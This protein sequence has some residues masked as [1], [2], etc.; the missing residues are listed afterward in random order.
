LTIADAAEQLGVTAKTVRE[1]I[2]KGIIPAPP[3]FDYGVRRMFHFPSDYMKRAKAEIEKHKKNRA[4][5]HK[6]QMPK[7]TK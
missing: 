2:M 4:N 6:R 3:E 7:P 1:Y 5:K